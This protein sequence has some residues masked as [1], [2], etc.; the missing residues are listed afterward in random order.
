MSRRCNR[1]HSRG[2]L[3]TQITALAHPSRIVGTPQHETG[4]AAHC[5]PEE[6]FYVPNDRC[7]NSNLARVWLR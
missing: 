6:R 7:S 4:I 5:K 1:L 3:Y 2:E